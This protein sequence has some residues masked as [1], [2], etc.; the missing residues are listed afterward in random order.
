MNKKV[1][2]ALAAVLSAAMAASAFAMST[3]ASFAASVSTANV[4]ATPVAVSIATN[5]TTSDATYS[6]PTTADP[7]FT[8]SFTVDGREVSA[9][10]I[11]F[12]DGS[13]WQ[14][15]NENIASV[16]NGTV[17]IHRKYVS[18]VQSVTF[19]RSL[20][21]T[22]E[23][24]ETD[25]HDHTET[26]T[27][28]VTGSITMY[29]YPSG[30]KLILP[31]ADVAAAD[32]GDYIESAKTVSM[33]EETDFGVYTV[34]AAGSADGYKAKY[35]E[36]TSYKFT[37]SSNTIDIDETDGT[38]TAVAANPVTGT[39]VISAVKDGEV[40][41]DVVS[42]TLT[43]E[44]SYRMSAGAGEKTAKNVADNYG[45]V[46]RTMIGGWDVTNTPIKV[47]PSATFTVE[48]GIVG[49]ITAGEGSTVTVNGGTTGD[50]TGDTVTVS[51]TKESVTIGAINADTV[52]IT[53][54][55]TETNHVFDSVETDDISATTVQITT[56]DNANKTAPEGQGAVATGDITVGTKLTLKAGE[57]VNTMTVGAL[58]GTEGNYSDCPYEAM[59][60]VNQGTFDLGD[61]PYFGEV[62]VDVKANVTAGTIATGTRDASGSGACSAE[63]KSKVV[64][65][66]KLTA[67]KVETALVDASSNGVLTVP[68]NS[69]IMTDAAQGK[70]G[71]TLIVSGVTKGDVLYSTVGQKADLFN[72]PGVTAVEAQG[73]GNTYDYI[74]DELTF[75]GIVAD[76]GRTEIG[77]SPVTLSVSKV[78]AS[79]DL[80]EDVTVEWTANKDSVTLTPS[81]DGLSCTVTATGYTEN[82][83][84]NSNNVEIT[85]T[86]VDA[87]GTPI[88]TFES[89]YRSAV[90]PVVLTNAAPEAPANPFTVVVTN[91]EGEKITCAADGSTVITVP[92]SMAFNFAISSEETQPFDYTVGDGSIGGTNTN[93][94]WNGTSG[95]YQIYAA[96]AVGSE[97]GAYVNGIKIFT[98]KVTDRPFE[99]D[100]TLNMD[101][102]VGQ[103]YQFEITLDD[104][105]APFTFLTADGAALST[106]YNPDTY[107]A[108]NGKYYCSVTAQQA[109]RDIGVYCVIDG[110]TYKIFTAH[111]VA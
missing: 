82:N 30:T 67:Q 11:K 59:L 88:T 110:K 97:T 8:A 20:D 64:V 56:S 44:N 70:T 34:S 78:P 109:G 63:S 68:A 107:P 1:S 38:F 13:T 53:G 95:Q 79:A 52:T 22:A 86:L 49:D 100:T 66:G 92:Q 15:S 94:V 6:L 55:T 3:S 7:T 93:T 27:A 106:S 80:P 104:P 5:E 19:T 76:Q 84:N 75:R 33:N 89:Q 39:T 91:A 61:L 62:Q 50:I 42:A 102:K 60:V 74:A 29:I 26:L 54:D 105:A 98:L 16:S 43:V 83:I 36:D 37:D 25:K 35:T 58:S 101:L 72:I 85:A 103:K 23:N 12:T 99:S 71:A 46:V 111:T 51:P 14:S 47:D 45:E 28:T 10:S 40:D 90:I 2:K 18:S 31:T 32:N 21:I 73:S 4:E 24:V 41:R 17:T 69:L 81:A 96:G 65:N 77:T 87:D 57:Y 108:E 9:T 48:S